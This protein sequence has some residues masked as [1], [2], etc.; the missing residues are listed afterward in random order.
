MLIGNIE[1]EAM[2]LYKMDLNGENSVKL[3]NGSVHGISVL[4]DRSYI[5]RI[6]VAKTICLV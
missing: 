4:E 5:L 3:D 1:T 2:E 6:I